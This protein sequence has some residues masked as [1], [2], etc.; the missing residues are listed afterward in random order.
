MSSLHPRVTITLGILAAF[1]VVAPLA[2]QATFIDIGLLGPAFSTLW[3]VNNQD[4]AV[5]WSE[6]HG[7]DSEHAILWKDGALVDLGVVPGD[8][9]S[10]ALGINEQGDVVG[11][12]A[13]TTNFQ[14][15]AVA[16]I[17]GR[18]VD[19]G[20]P[21]CV[22]TA[23]NNRGQIVLSCGLVVSLRGDAPVPIRPLPGYTGVRASAIN[24]AGV[25]VGDMLTSIGRTEA[26]R[27]EHGEATVLSPS[28]D[29]RPS[30][31]TAINDRGQIVLNVTTFPGAGGIEPALWD[32]GRAVPL[33][34]SWGR[35]SAQA[36]GINARGEVVGS[37]ADLMT[38]RGGA[39]VWAGGTIRFL[40][41]ANGVAIDIN[42]RGV[43]VGRRYVEADAVQEGVL[44]LKPATR[45]LPA[46]PRLT[47]GP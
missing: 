11:L 18:I 30:S 45:A 8:T 46:L 27:W 28:V 26:F 20:F 9:A 23:I 29:G 47:T 10:R 12:S 4:Q 35:L 40:E 14:A 5:G 44:W 16:W 41:P 15:R 25:V 2:G 1:V 34:G 13:D 3:A 31:A 32:R 36:W 7:L 43:A 42:D 19:L 17:D 22:A 24:D 6:T 21:G 38:S 37:G 39:F 33:G